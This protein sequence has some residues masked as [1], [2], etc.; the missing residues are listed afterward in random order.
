MELN[1]HGSQGWVSTMVVRNLALPRQSCPWTLGNG[2]CLPLH[3]TWGEAEWVLGMQCSEC[4]NAC[5]SS[6]LA[7]EIRCTG[8]TIYCNLIL[9][10]F[11]E[12][13]HFIYVKHLISCAPSLP[14]LCIVMSPTDYGYSWRS[15]VSSYLWG[16]ISLRK[17]WSWNKHPIN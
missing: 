4:M 12:S 11:P 8:H 2:G 16:K 7:M 1:L 10:V 9:F 6:L 15:S 5:Y 17:S 13:A 14:I 3:R